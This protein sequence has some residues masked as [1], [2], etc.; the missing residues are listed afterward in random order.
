[1]KKYRPEKTERENSYKQRFFEYGGRTLEDLQ[2]IM[3]LGCYN[4]R[5]LRY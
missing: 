4:I 2:D 3:T 5:T 1:L